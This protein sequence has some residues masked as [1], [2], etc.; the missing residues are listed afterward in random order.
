MLNSLGPD[1]AV[2][3]LDSVHPTHDARPVGCWA[4][5]EENLAIEQTTGRQRINNPG[6]IDLKTG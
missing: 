1:E 6:A 3:F 4:P 2:L 5:K